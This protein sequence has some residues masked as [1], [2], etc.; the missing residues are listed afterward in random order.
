LE[1]IVFICEVLTDGQYFG[2]LVE[3]EIKFIH[4]PIPL[5]KVDKEVLDLKL[6]LLLLVVVA[7]VLP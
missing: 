1:Q 5:L 4:F 6:N 3:S 7:S 2:H